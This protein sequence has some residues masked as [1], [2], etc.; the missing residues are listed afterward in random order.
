MHI[1][2]STDEN[3]SMQPE[4]N[5]FFSSIYVWGQMMVFQLLTN[6]KQHSENVLDE[7]PPIISS[8]YSHFN[9]RFPNIGG[10]MKL[11]FNGRD[12]NIISL[13][14]SLY[15]QS[16]YNFASTRLLFLTYHIENL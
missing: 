4:M 5:T 3:I 16:T 10:N 7:I 6:F 15:L 2:E 1:N 14:F 9:K 12:I 8:Y 11:H 13:L